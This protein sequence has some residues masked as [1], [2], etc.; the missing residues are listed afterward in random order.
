MYASG[1]RN[2]Q[3]FD[4]DDYGNLF[5]IDHDADFQGEMER[6]V[7]LPEG[8]DSGWRN[9][10]QYRTTNR[11]L[12][13]AAKDLYSPWLAEQMWKPLHDGQPAHF[14][15]PIENSW[16]A[17]AAFSFQ[18]GEALGGRYRGH[19]LLG[20]M[21]V[22]RAF[23]MVADGA[24]FRREGEDVVVGGLGA[25]VLSSAF[26]PDGR[27]YFTL[28]NPPQ[29]RGPLWALGGPGG[30]GEV[31]LL[32]GE[33]FGGRDGDELV[34]LLGHPDRRVRS[35]AQF[36]LAARGDAGVLK[37]VVMDGGAATLARTHALW[38]L[39]Q[40]RFWDA[41]IAGQL[42]RSEEPELIA[43][44]ARWTG[45]VGRYD[46]TGAARDEWAPVYHSHGSL[47]V[48]MLAAIACGRLGSKGGV[49][50]IVGMIE[51][52]GNRVPILREAGVI[53]LMGVAGLEDLAGMSG[54][55]SEA[56]RTAAVVAL[57]RLGGFGELMVFLD[58]P[59]P[60]VVGEAVRG[61]YDT[62]DAGVF[63]E[64]PE[65]MEAVA[66]KLGPGWSRGVRIRALA[67]NRRVG[68]PEAVGRVLGFLTDGRTN[69]RTERI[70]AMD[71]LAS[72][73]IESALDPVDGRH[74]PVAAFRAGDVEAAF[75]GGGWELVYDDDVLVA[76][77]AIGLL[78]KMR[79]DE[80]MVDRAVEQVLDEAVEVPIRLAWLRWLG[81]RDAGRGDGVAV[82]CLAAGVYDVR[83]AAAA[84]LLEREMKTEEVG[85]YLRRVLKEGAGV[86]EQQGALAM[87]GRF[88]E[89]GVVLH[90]LVD[91]LVVG[92]VAPAI[93]L[94]V[95]EAARGSAAKDAK[96][97]EALGRY[98]AWVRSQEPFGEFG[99]A[100]EGGDA[101]RGRSVFLGHT[102]A[103]CSKCHALKETDKQV[104]PSLQGVGRRLSRVKLL[105]SV[106]DPQA[107]VV[108]GYGIQS[109]ELRDGSG[110]VGTQVEESADRL[111]LKMPD[112]QLVEVKRDEIKSMTAPVGG[113]PGM[114]GILSIREVRDLVAFLGSLTD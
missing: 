63:V 97:Q 6:L 56:V 16:N 109:L 92:D 20:G 1:L 52:A 70:V 96:L 114:R 82:A 39:T 17:P 41:E 32:L 93:R 27:L 7:Y 74:F 37:R 23:K 78:A 62:A 11:V 84:Y 108:P 12:G 53:G 88:A 87:L 103:Q 13:D 34:G 5:A 31:E 86:R 2:C 89:R 100:L 26:G 15:P 51:A 36:E 79:A 104:G 67:A 60:A 14:L 43:Q 113:M 65:A 83:E 30:V 24:S 42:W 25:Q 35:G 81:E 71:I 111:T 21:G 106:L 9:Y 76:E 73:G 102:A 69:D 105:E 50:S 98:E 38:G 90:D 4:F 85:R 59:S 22:V 3:Y 75:L 57:R 10:Y 99:V 68:T 28:W 95:L 64:Y 112:G 66:R 18:P 54:H 46:G 77:R 101:R 58:D 44:A 33:G 19:F 61:I 72:W 48:K 91:D 110:L 45:D 94:D 107:E 40:L 80:E 49:G 55:G 8:S 29:G 47:R